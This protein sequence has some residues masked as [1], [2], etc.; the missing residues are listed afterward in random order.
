MKIKS[1]L[2]VRLAL[3]FVMVLLVG[4]SAMPMLPPRAV[5]ADAP[6]SIFSARRAMADL[7]IVASEP[8]GAGSDGQARVRDYIVGQ[9]EALGLKAEVETSGKLSNILVRLPGTDSTQMV[10]VTGHYDSHPP[11]PGAGDDGLSTVAMLESIRVLHASPSLRN[12]VLFL[13]TDGEELGYLGSSAYL[14]ANPLAKNEIGVVLCFDGVP[15]NAPLTLRQTS[16]GDAW[17]VQQMTG[18]RLSMVAGSWINRAERGEIDCDCSI[19]DAAGYL[20]LEFENEHTGT[21]YHS[22]R[23]TVDAISPNLVQ[24]YGKTMLALA[25]QFGRIDL[26]T[27]ST[28]PDLVYFTLPLVGLVSYPGWMMP[29]LSG[30]GLVVLLAFVVVSW[31]RGILSPG[32]FGFSMLCLLA[33]IVLIVLIAQIAWGGVKNNHAVELVAGNGFD[34]SAAWMAGFMIGTAVLMII[35]LSLQARYFGWANLLLAALVLYLLIWV[36]VYFLMD[37]D[38]VFTA[39]FLVWPLLGSVGGMGILLFTKNPVWKVVLLSF[40][41]LVILTLQIPYFW[42]G[43]YTGEDA[44]I[45]VLVV[46]LAMGLF[47]PQVDVIFGRTLTPKKIG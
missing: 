6:A 10:L 33:G 45:P 26:R 8:H 27:H 36:A 16:P 46:C 1:N 30:L 15:G 12:D 47:V 21:R 28:G 4:L 19:F 20:T 44:W 17:L 41:A 31:Q 37:A 42:L 32:R 5:P 14:K 13:F 18:L 39:P 35:L 25:D 11:S 43:S 40:C 9:I 3:G 24:S 29:L 22:S 34:E 23:D 7:E 2:I 38:N